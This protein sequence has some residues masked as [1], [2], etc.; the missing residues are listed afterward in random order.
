MADSAKLLLE[1]ARKSRNLS[2][3]QLAMEL[4][5]SVDTIF[6]WED[7]SGKNAKCAP[8]PDTVDR[9]AT[10]LKM[11]SLWHQ[12]MCAQFESYRKRH[13]ECEQYG[14]IPS[15]MRLRHDIGDLV[16]LQ[17]KVELDVLD[18]KLDDPFLKETF[19]RE[20]REAIESL[21]QIVEA[22]TA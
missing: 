10:V 2:R 22:I 15:V 13:L 7:S 20:A 21:R 8:D 3:M 18:G 5:E 11:P 14:L 6:R 19:I 1:I 16:R 17:D 9:I 12:W 4:G